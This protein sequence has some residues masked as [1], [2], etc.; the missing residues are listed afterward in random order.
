MLRYHGGDEREGLLSELLDPNVAA[1]A[2]LLATSRLPSS[3]SSS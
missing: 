3:R 1:L 2:Q